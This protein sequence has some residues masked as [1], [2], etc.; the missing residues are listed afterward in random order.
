M[1]KSP[2]GRK[3]SK[4]EKVHHFW[5]SMCA[6]T[7]RFGG[8][9]VQHS[10]FFAGFEDFVHLLSRT[11]NWRFF[12]VAEPPSRWWPIW[13]SDEWDSWKFH[14]E[15]W[16]WFQPPKAVFWIGKRWNKSDIVQLDHIWPGTLVFLKIAAK[17]KEDQAVLR[18]RKGSWTTSCWRWPPNFPWR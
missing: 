13:I 7:L 14:I 16:K 2:N 18:M 8:A 12:A 4:P 15:N 1:Q 10:A 9:G 6:E 17:K 11:I 3:K 5:F